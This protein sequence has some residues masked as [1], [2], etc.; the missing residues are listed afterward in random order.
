MRLSKN[1]SPYT[2]NLLAG[3]CRTVKT[4]VITPVSSKTS[5]TSRILFSVLSYDIFNKP[6]YFNQRTNKPLLP[7]ILRQF[8]KIQSTK[9][10]STNTAASMKHLKKYASGTCIHATRLYLPGLLPR[11][12]QQR[13]LHIVNAIVPLLFCVFPRIENVGR[14]PVSSAYPPLSDF[15]N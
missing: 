8:Q 2:V 15:P 12:T 13:P 5:A 6:V 1:C 3:S 14:G 10:H 4:F 7:Y 11:D 9:C